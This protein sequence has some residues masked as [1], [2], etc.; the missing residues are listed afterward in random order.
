MADKTLNEA[1][2]EAYASV[3]NDDVVLFC[4]EIRHPSFDAPIR[5][6]RDNANFTCNLEGN[7]P[8]NPGEEVTFIAYAFDVSLPDI[9]ESGKPEMTITIDNVSREITEALERAVTSIHKIEVT[10]RLYLLS[11]PSGPQ[12]NPPLS[13]VINS[14]IADP[15]KITAT[16]GFQDLTKNAFPRINYTLDKFPS[17]AS[18][19]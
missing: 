6:V 2:K 17:L 13:M 19:S 14:V 3:T 4:L 7:A 9:D 16:A 11:D 12:N 5:V 18:V 8:L 1:V 10:Y 15:M